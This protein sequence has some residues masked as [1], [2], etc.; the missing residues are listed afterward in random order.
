MYSGLKTAAMKARHDGQL[1]EQE[2][3]TYIRSG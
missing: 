3:Q 2:A 1:T